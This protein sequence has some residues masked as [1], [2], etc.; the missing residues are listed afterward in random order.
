MS[1]EI[2]ETNKGWFPLHRVLWV[3]PP[4]TGKWNEPLAAVVLDPRTGE[5]VEVMTDREKLSEITSGT[6]DIHS[7]EEFPLYIQAVP[8][9]VDE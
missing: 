4:G 9:E 8:L 2:L 7:S 3:A 1:V 5:P 6:T